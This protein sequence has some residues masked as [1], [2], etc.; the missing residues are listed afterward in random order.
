MFLGD[1]LNCVP[2]E[3]M[4]RVGDDDSIVCTGGGERCL[5]LLATV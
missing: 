2:S 5:E 4:P 3:F 1:G